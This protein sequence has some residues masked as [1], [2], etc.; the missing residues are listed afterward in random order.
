MHLGEQIP[1]GQRK[2]P[3]LKSRDGFRLIKIIYWYS[4]DITVSPSF[5]V[6]GKPA[7]S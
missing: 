7:P 1:S 6:K 5:D 4:N 2:N 3:P